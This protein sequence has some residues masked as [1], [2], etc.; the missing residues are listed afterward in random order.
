MTTTTVPAR[1][2]PDFSLDDL[3]EDCREVSGVLA[4]FG[5]NLTVD[6]TRIPAPRGPVAGH[7]P[8]E[9]PAGAAATVDG[10]EAY[11]S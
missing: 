5:P 10:Y 8:V 9:I 11:G 1:R 3:V 6:L 2:E 7:L 4:P